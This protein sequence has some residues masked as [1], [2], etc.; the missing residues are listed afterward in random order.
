MTWVSVFLLVAACLI[1]FIAYVIWLYRFKKSKF[2]D[3]DLILD[4]LRYNTRNGGYV[5]FKD[6]ST[7]FYIR[8]VRYHA[9]S[10][11]GIRIVAP[12]DG[13]TRA[14]RDAVLSLVE[15]YPYASQTNRLNGEE[16]LSV[17]CGGNVK[18]VKDISAN[19]FFDI[20]KLSRRT[21]FKYEYSH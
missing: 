13:M 20:V 4:L 1:L 15:G 7:G 5:G 8:Y 16:F 10:G 6:L 3:I 12:M 2:S 11:F 19:I 17:D 18:D 14:E 21:R 9:S